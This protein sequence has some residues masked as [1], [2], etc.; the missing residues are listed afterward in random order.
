ME[1]LANIS[2][3]SVCLKT[4]LKFIGLCFRD[5]RTNR[6]VFMELFFF[7]PLLTSAFHHILF[8]FDFA[9]NIDLF[10]SFCSCLTVFIY[11]LDHSQTNFPYGDPILGLFFELKQWTKCKLMGKVPMYLI[12][13]IL[14]FLKDLFECWLFYCVD[15]WFTCYITFL[16]WPW[17]VTVL[18]CNRKCKKIRK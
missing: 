4:V 12:V 17:V 2:S 18:F 15:W 7:V 9:S 11:L 8:N 14:F 5:F 13:L 3:D 16:L 1:Q 6:L 10:Y